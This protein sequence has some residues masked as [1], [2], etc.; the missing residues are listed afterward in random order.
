MTASTHTSTRTS[1]H[2]GTSATAAP[3][4]PTGGARS[5]Y[6][7]ALLVTAL[8]F[9]LAIS[10]QSFWL[11][12][13]HTAWRVSA[14]DVAGLVRQMLIDTGSDA[15]M[16][17]FLGALWAWEKLVGNGEIALRAFNL[18]WILPGIVLFADGRIERLAVAAT[19]AFLWFYIDEARPYM[20]QIGASLAVFGLIARMAGAGIPGARPLGVHAP[21]LLAIALIVLSGSSMLGE[22]W[23]LAA[24]ATLIWIRPGAL[25]WR[26]LFWPLLL[27][28]AVLVP[29]SLYYLWT[30]IGGVGGTKVGSTDLRN[31]FVIVYEFLGFA[32]LGPGR[33]ELRAEGTRALLP[34][35]VPLALHAALV[36]TVLAAGCHR[37]LRQ[38]PPRV[39][40]G[41]ALAV[42][43][44]AGVI[45]LAGYLLHW[46]V[47]G[48]HLAPGIAVVLALLSTGVLALWQRRLGRLI[49]LAFLVSALC[50]SLSL[51]FAPRHAKDDYR[52]A[53]ALAREDLSRGARVWWSADPTAGQFYGLRI[54]TGCD[55][56]RYVTEPPP[57]A[58]AGR[59]LPA[60]VI[61]SKPDIYDPEGKLAE[62]LAQ[63]GYR[64][65]GQY[66]AF[67]LL[68]PADAAAA[69]PCQP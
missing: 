69:A 8:A 1:T 11:D 49:V 44:A 61:A 25:P 30:V 66:P 47:L 45:L 42:L 51:R 16:P 26:V 53:A 6:Y 33:T 7:L 40:I 3:C 12:E 31:L 65:V 35:L 37:I 15:Q 23:A 32:G 43:G 41:A 56:A 18:I 24:L 20:M 59:D 58:A 9:C 14:P 55:G 54:A 29:L 48:R 64:V 10:G 4:D 21:W 36:V 34:H 22:I 62:F 50:S 38:L 46:R 52:A 63:A 60:L 17:L 39:L 19:S 28:A 13:G 2:T 67:Q 57:E 5:L 68:R 27:V